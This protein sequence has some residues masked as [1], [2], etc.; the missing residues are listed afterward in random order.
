MR[1]YIKRSLA[2]CLWS[3]GHILLCGILSDLFTL[4]LRV[5]N[6][7]TFESIVGVTNLC[8]EGQELYD[9]IAR[10]AKIDACQ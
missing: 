8:G 9:K 2:A 3:V 4:F 10:I 1:F 7:V 5:H 6:P